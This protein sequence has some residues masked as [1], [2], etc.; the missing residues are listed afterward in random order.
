MPEDTLERVGLGQE[1]PVK[2]N[3]LLER[4]KLELLQTRLQVTVEQK[5]AGVKGKAEC[6]FAR[7]KEEP[8]RLMV[9]WTGKGNNFRPRAI[10]V[11]VYDVIKCQ[12][13]GTLRNA[14]LRD[15]IDPIARCGT[16]S[17]E[18]M[19]GI[20]KH[21][22]QTM[23]LRFIVGRKEGFFHELE[24]WIDRD[25]IKGCAKEA[26][27]L[28]NEYPIVAS[29]PFLKYRETGTNAHWDQRKSSWWEPINGFWSYT[30]P[31]GDVITMEFRNLPNVDILNKTL[32]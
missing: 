17:Y 2:V 3:R 9:I 26:E 10:K 19:L 21:F 13:T 8:F 28:D 12:D 20:Y 22:E 16:E 30:N 14:D 5:G 25:D 7:S 29:V 6:F 23:E 11:A 15:P 27:W 24:W 1:I 31:D 18:W 32:K 4:E